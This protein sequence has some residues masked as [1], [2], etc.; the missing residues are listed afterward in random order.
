MQVHDH[1]L[2]HARDKQRDELLLQAAFDLE[3]AGQK[4][5]ADYLRKRARDAPPFQIGR[6]PFNQ[7]SAS[8]SKRP[9]LE[10]ADRPP[11]PAFVFAE[12]TQMPDSR[13]V[14]L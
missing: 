12:F 2:W 11:A 1:Q 9:R 6:R 14:P 10:D 3:M 8:A 13:G 5:R 7:G 4:Q